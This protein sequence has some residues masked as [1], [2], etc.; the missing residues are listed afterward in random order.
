MENRQIGHR[1]HFR[2]STPNLSTGDSDLL[3]QHVGVL[4]EPHAEAL[5]SCHDHG[6]QVAGVQWRR[7]A[8]LVHDV[9]A[10]RADGTLAVRGIHHHLHLRHRATA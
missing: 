7:T 2:C 9:A 10:H 3:I 1:R 6:V 4:R 5:E 8:A